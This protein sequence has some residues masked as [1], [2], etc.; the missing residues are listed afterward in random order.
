MQQLMA[1]VT[2]GV[3]G[4]LFVIG[5]EVE[6]PGRMAIRALH[7]SRWR[8]PTMSMRQSQG[9]LTGLRAA[10]SSLKSKN[11]TRIRGNQVLEW[12]G[13]QHGTTRN[14]KRLIGKLREELDLQREEG[15]DQ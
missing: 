5:E 4:A 8:S 3:V 2:H 12:H 11:Y 7:R 1:P 6:C 10:Y 14:Q 9:S 13:G 15:P